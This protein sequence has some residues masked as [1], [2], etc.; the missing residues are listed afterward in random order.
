MPKEQSRTY[1]PLRDIFDHIA[2]VHHHA[3]ECCAKVAHGPDEQVQVLADF[4]RQREETFGTY[5]KSLEGGQQTA[6]LDTWL[7]Y[8]PTQDLVE[9]L[10]ALRA[11]RN[12]KDSNAIF[13]KCLELQGKIVA[14]LKQLAANL[15]APT[16]RD[17]LQNL[18]VSEEAALK[19]LET[20]KVTQDDA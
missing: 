16:V 15:H 8:V 4:F 7:Q 6:V 1:Q 19:P 13:T 5:S 11:A 20:A 2:H 17:V 3:A 10:T 14:L 18:A 9:A 12:Q